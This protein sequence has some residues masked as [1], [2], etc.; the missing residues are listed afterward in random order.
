MS[1]TG[2]TV[3]VINEDGTQKVKYTPKSGFSQS[4]G[5]DSFTYTIKDD[6]GATS[7]ATVTVGVGAKPNEKP[8]AKDDEMSTP[9]GAPVTIDVL[10]NDSDPEGQAI[11]IKEVNSNTGATVEIV[12]GKVKYTPKS[13]FN[14]AGGNDSFTYTIE[15]VQGATDSAS[16]TVSVG[17]KT[18]GAPLA[19][20]DEGKTPYGTPVLIDVLANDSDP[21][22]D[23]I[24]IYSVKSDTGA[25]VQIVNGKVQYTPKP[26]FN[27]AGGYDSFTYTIKDSEGN[28]SSASVTVRVGGSGELPEEGEGKDPDPEA[29]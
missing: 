11:I 27:T 4:G 22:G 5:N 18:N 16:V 3:Q 26:N 21:E 28:T 19:V 12:D 6:R 9:Y 23:T 13:N 24:M 10:A 7:S 20:N 15:D 29:D 14:T 8:V 25:T 1:S 2:S 17:A